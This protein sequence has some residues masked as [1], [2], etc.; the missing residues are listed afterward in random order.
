MA[1]KVKKARSKSIE[2]KGPQ[3]HD[4]ESHYQYLMRKKREEAEE[5][6]LKRQDARDEMARKREAKLQDE[7]DYRQRL[8][9]EHAERS[10]DNDGAINDLEN[11]AAGSG[12]SRSDSDED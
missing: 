6:E 12:G 3:L 5:V 9:D 7:W 8:E 11:M 1:A 4:G 10:G 2:K